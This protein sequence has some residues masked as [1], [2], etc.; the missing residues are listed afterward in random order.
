MKFLQAIKK[1]NWTLFLVMMCTAMIGAMQN[2][3]VESFKEAFVLGLIGGFVF[4]LPWAIL[5]RDEH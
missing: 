3:N 1:W 4:G 2:K 5:S